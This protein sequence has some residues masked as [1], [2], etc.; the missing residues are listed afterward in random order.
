MHNESASALHPP[1]IDYRYRPVELK[2]LGIQDGITLGLGMELGEFKDWM[3]HHEEK[4]GRSL[5]ADERHEFLCQMLPSFSPTMLI[6][7]LLTRHLAFSAQTGSGKTELMLSVA[8]Q[9]IARG[10]GMIIFEAKGKEGDFGVTEKVAA[11]CEQ[12]GRLDDFEYFSMDDAENCMTWNPWIAKK[13][14]RSDQYGYGAPA[15]RRRA[16]L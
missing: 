15:N 5:S 12:Y 2:D 10:G 13:P 6:D 3:A 14:A 7:D 9:Q 16:V 11:L 8:D 1:P 4:I